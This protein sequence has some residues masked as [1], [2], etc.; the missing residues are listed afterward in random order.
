MIKKEEIE[1]LIVKHINNQLNAADA[2]LL[3]KWLQSPK[4]QKLFKEYITLNFSL[5]QLKGVD[6]GLKNTTW[7]NIENNLQAKSRRIQYWKYAVAA[8]VVLLISTS[9]FLN[10][11]S[12]GSETPEVVTN[13]IVPGTD[14]AVLTIENG[15]NITLVEGQ[16]Y[17]LEHL[18]TD[19]TQLAY[20]SNKGSVDAEVKYNYLT[21]P[22]GGQFLVKLSDGTKV[23]LNSDSKLKYPVSF[24]KGTSRD[25]EL[26]YGEAYFDVS[27]SEEHGGSAF[28]VFSKNQELEVLGTEFNIKAY[29]NE[30]DIATTL[31][32]GK[33]SV[34]NADI[35]KTLAPGEQSKFNLETQDFSV[36]KVNIYDVISWRQGVFSFEEVP[37]SEIVKVLARWYDVDFEFKNEAIKHEAFTGVLNKNQNL[38][39]ILHTI[40]NTNNMKFKTDAKKIILE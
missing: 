1:I 10:R 25:V 12:I 35:S 39:H 40:K 7:N 27:P 33:V 34:V 37:L 31:V 3:N 23:W 18:V 24:L 8:A 29:D 15:A 5:E 17:N 9:I 11:D 22:R 21:I 20:R 19:G 36:G 14:K 30:A 26:V 38:E 2:R 16:E 6:I 4:N 28:R 13:N 32:E